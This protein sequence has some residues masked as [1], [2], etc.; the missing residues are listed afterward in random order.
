MD[1]LNSPQYNKSLLK[2]IGEDVF[3][4]ANVEIRRPQLV[5]IGNH[6]AID[7]GFYLTTGAELGDYIHIG[8]Y[9]VIIGGQQGFLKMGHF[10]NIAAG[11]KVI[12]VS[13]EYLGEGLVTAPGLLAKFRD[14]LK[15]KPVIFENF[16]NVG[17]NTVIFPG[18][19]LGEGSVIGAC[20]LV[21]KDT[22]PWTIYVGTPARPVK[23]R[24]KDKMLRYAKEM[25][26]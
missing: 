16:A 22:E 20:S 18:V 3:I 15:S 24:P 6:V 25:G 5:S 10:T 12:C 21:T 8:P 19:T 1:Q 4:S 2:N 26:Y 11:S 17:V 9:V 13:D 7:T 23:T 14:S